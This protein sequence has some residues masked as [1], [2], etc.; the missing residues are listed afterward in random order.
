MTRTVLATNP[1]LLAQLPAE[2]QRRALDVIRHILPVC[3]RAAG[4]WAD[5]RDAAA[6]GASRLRDIAVPTLCVSAADD[7]FGTHDGAR[8]VAANVRR[9]KLVLFPDG[10]HALAG[11]GAEMTQNVLEFLRENVSSFSNAAQW[12]SMRS[13]PVSRDRA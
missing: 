11:R 1:K 2:E 10:G 13:W 6:L 5:R 7:Y 12:Q 4:I 8:Y 9:G 3:L